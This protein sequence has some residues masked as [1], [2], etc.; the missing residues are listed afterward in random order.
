MENELIDEITDQQRLQNH[1]NSIADSITNPVES[2]DD[3]E[4]NDAYAYLSDVLD[5]EY[6]IGSD[7]EY[8]SAQV[9]VAFGGPN[10]YV[11]TADMRVKGYWWMTKAD[12]EFEDT[13]GLDDALR[14]LYEM[15]RA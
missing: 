12:A 9:L 15:G 7:G 10:I 5:I 2:D 8:R 4:P 11:D 6:R 3:D 13:L 14:D 1:V